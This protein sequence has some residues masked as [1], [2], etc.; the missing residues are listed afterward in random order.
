MSSAPAVGPVVEKV[1]RT[2]TIPANEAAKDGKVPDFW[3]YIESLTPE[4]WQDHVVY[5]Y[6]EEPKVSNYGGTAYLDKFSGYIDVRPGVQVPMEE[7]GMIEAAIKEKFGGKAF[8]LICKKGRERITEG[9]CVNEAP[10]KYPD[11]QTQHFAGPLP[12]AA[13][14]ANTIAAKAIDTV[15]NHPQEALRIAQESL[16]TTAEIISR[17][18]HQV[19][20]PATPATSTESDLD[21]AFK[22]AMITRMTADPVES[23]LRMREVFTPPQ[24]SMMEK[25]IGIAMERMLNPAPVVSGRTTLLDLGREALPV[26]AG[27]VREAMTNWRMGVEAQ[28]DAIAMQRGMN[29]GPAVSVAP[30]AASSGQP[31]PP[32]ASA[33]TQ[34]PPAVQPQHNNPG[35]PVSNDPPF[36]WLEMKIVEIFKDQEYTVDQAV[37]ETLAFLYRAHPAVVALLLDPPKLDA[38][39]APGEQGL[40]QLFQNRP[41]LQQV[42]VG[43]RLTE[44]IK[45]FIAAAK[46]AE[47]GR[48]GASTAATPANSAPS[49]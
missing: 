11:M 41:I 48:I 9:K 3:D 12:N 32:A 7:R 45:K 34:P 29:P 8:R 42:Q 38:R 21:R 37:D 30:A 43:P 46:E 2:R 31:L 27:T 36:E 28:R 35:A 49:A 44:F 10:P 15:A 5:L 40:L 17:L 25:F 18:G 33:E 16:R 47:A 20:A 22:A 19:G 1:T 39:L 23:F 6:R 14:D 4:Q 26:L 13:S 24:N